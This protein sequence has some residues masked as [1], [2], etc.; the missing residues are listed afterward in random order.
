MNVRTVLAAGVLTMA[1]V[2]S[3]CAGGTEEAKGGQEFLNVSYDPTRELYQDINEA[4]SQ[5]WQAKTGT[6][7]SFGTIYVDDRLPRAQGQSERHSGLGRSRAGRCDR[8][9]AESE[10]IGR[11]ALELS[12]VVGVCE[13]EERRG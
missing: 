7:V 6:Q 8:R 11:R 3:G 10:D 9:N 2:L 1:V 4:F 12:R 13:R 5:A